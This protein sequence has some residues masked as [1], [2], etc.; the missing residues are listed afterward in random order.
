MGAGIQS[1]SAVD[2]NDDDIIKNRNANEFTATV[3]AGTST[4]IR[5]AGLSW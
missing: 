1:S 2:G 3:C 5:G 4:P